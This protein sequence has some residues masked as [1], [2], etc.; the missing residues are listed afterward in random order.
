MLSDCFLEHIFFSTY[1]Q[2]SSYVR[3]FRT[4]T[5]HTTNVGPQCMYAIPAMTPI[6]KKFPSLSEKIPNSRN[7]R[8]QKLLQKW[9]GLKSLLAAAKFSRIMSLFN[10]LHFIWGSNIRPQN[11]PQ[12]IYRTHDVSDSRTKNGAGV[13]SLLAAVQCSRI[14]SLFNVIAFLLRHQYPSRTSTAPHE[15]L[16]LDFLEQFIVGHPN[17]KFLKHAVQPYWKRYI[18]CVRTTDI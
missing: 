6:A 2:V 14:M 16:P 17:A 15:K 3:W 12:R 13:K 5:R 18:Y 9:A 8:I 4:V 10:P 11:Q 7:F 1:S